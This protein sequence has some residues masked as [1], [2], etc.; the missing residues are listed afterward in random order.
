[1]GRSPGCPQPGLQNL[2]WPVLRAPRRVAETLRERALAP[3][4][5]CVFSLNSTFDNGSERR[6]IK[7][8]KRWGLRHIKMQCLDRPAF[9]TQSLWNWKLE[10]KTPTDGIPFSP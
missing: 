4:V 5:G 9:E 8:D 10:D 6:E 1:M 2:S 3:Y 7:Q